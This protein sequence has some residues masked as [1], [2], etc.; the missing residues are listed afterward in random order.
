MIDIYQIL[1]KY[2]P[3]DDIMADEADD[4]PTRRIKD[5]IYNQ[6]DEV[7]RRVFLMYVELASLRKLAKEIGVSATACHFKVRDIKNKILAKL[8]DD[9]DKPFDNK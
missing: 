3:T 4:T 6:L 8:N 1:S 9:I 7:D 5:I 2:Q